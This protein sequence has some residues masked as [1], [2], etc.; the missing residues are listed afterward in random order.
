[1]IVLLY[2]LVSH[3]KEFLNAYKVCTE[4]LLH[5]WNYIESQYELYRSSLNLDLWISGFN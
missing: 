5:V 4:I 3:M 2:D 1:M